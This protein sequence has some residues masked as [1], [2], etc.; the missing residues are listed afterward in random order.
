MFLLRYTL[1]Q[2][3]LE[4]LFCGAF[5]S[6]PHETLEEYFGPGFLWGYSGL[7]LNVVP[8]LLQTSRITAFQKGFHTSRLAR[9]LDP[10]ICSWVQVRA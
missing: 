5:Q 3:F 4:M 2:N 1:L 7:G 8:P 6:L 10:Q 9:S